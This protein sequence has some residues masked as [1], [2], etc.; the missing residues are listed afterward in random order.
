MLRFERYIRL[1]VELKVLKEKQMKEAM[2]DVKRLASL[3]DEET[4]NPW[5]I[6][7]LDYSLA[8]NPFVVSPPT[9]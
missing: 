2:N 1:P 5:V 9:P 4:I 8:G 6:S 7:D 3:R